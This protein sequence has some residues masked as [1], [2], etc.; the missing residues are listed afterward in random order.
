MKKDIYLESKKIVKL[1]IYMFI[2]LICICTPINI[3]LVLGTT[4]FGMFIGLNISK[5]I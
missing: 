4:L 2:V 3:A 5:L 1:F